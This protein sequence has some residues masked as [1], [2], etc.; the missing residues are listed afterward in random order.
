[1]SFLYQKVG[2]IV[3]EGLHWIKNLLSIHCWYVD[4][5]SIHHRKD[6]KCYQCADLV[7]KRTI[8]TIEASA[9][10]MAQAEGP[11]ATK[12]YKVIC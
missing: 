2:L 5:L 11:S 3:A 12:L 7:E 1:M 4:L 9:R 10:G 6:Y 8:C